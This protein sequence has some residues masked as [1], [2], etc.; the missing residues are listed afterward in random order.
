MTERSKS[1]LQLPRYKFVVQVVII[2]QK[3]QG[4]KM[5]CRSFWD[6]ETDNYAEVTYSNVSGQHRMT[7]AL[8]LGYCIG[9]I[10]MHCHLPRDLLL[11]ILKPQMDD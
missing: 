7:R 8:M 1:E 9:F 10:N 3:G 5:G 4:V 11:L 2:E 6:T